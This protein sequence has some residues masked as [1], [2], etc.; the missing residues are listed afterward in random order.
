MKDPGGLGSGGG[1]VGLEDIGTKILAGRKFIV[2][3]ETALA[4]FRAGESGTKPLTEVMSSIKRKH[5]GYDLPD[6]NFLR[7][8]D[9]PEKIAALMEGETRDEV[10]VVVR[11]SGEEDEEG[12]KGGGGYTRVLFRLKDG[13]YK[14]RQEE[15]IKHKDSDKLQAKDKLVLME[16]LSGPNR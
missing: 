10:Y 11:S 1:G 13:R 5:P 6:E 14:K 2:D 15:A 12:G 16:G 3:T 8:L 4:Q 9:T 7:R